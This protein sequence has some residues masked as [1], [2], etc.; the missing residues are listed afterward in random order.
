MQTIFTAK[1]SQALIVSGLVG[2][3]MTLVEAVAFWVGPGWSLMWELRRSE[4]TVQVVEAW[5]GA[6]RDPASQRSFATLDA[7]VSF[8]KRQGDAVGVSRVSIR[9]VY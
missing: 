4:S 2:P 1:Q 6:D 5:Q 9:V 3:G 7:L 8:V